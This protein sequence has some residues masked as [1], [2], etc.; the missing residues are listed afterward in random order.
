MH[1]HLAND[2]GFIAFKQAA[3]DRERQREKGCQNLL[4]SKRVTDIKASIIAPNRR[5]ILYFHDIIARSREI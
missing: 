5:S 4:Y 3:D 2:G 1:Y